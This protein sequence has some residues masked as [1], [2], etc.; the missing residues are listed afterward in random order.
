MKNSRYCFF[1]SPPTR[2]CTAFPE[3]ECLPYSF[4]WWISSLLV[5]CSMCYFMTLTRTAY[6]IC[7]QEEN[8]T[9]SLKKGQQAEIN[10]LWSRHTQLTVSV[11]SGWVNSNSS[12][13]RCWS[14]CVRRVRVPASA[15]SFFLFPLIFF[16][17]LLW[18]LAPPSS[19]SSFHS[20]PA[21]NESCCLWCQGE[22]GGG[23]M[24][25]RQNVNLSARARFCVFF[26]CVCVWL[27]ERACISSHGL[28]KIPFAIHSLARTHR[29]P[30]NPCRGIKQC[31][32]SERA[33]FS[34]PPTPPLSSFV[35]HFPLQGNL[36]F[37]PLTPPLFSLPLRQHYLLLFLLFH[38]AVLLQEWWLSKITKAVS[39]LW[40][41]RRLQA[42]A[43]RILNGPF[44]C[45]VALFSLWF[46]PS[47]W[48][49]LLWYWLLS[50][51]S[52]RLQLTSPAC[53]FVQQAFGC[54][55]FGTPAAV[56]WFSE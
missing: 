3:A 55:F 41:H 38:L 33:L 48:T 47:R 39:S 7:C 24:E 50:K 5:F 51:R 12:R 28:L 42:W 25:L 43:E 21:D 56:V 14:L 53:W 18:S 31:C 15:S 9:N 20:P 2:I 1:F 34:H 10:K 27:C 40:N 16:L 29:A 45:P 35:F 13:T 32:R 26:L 46:A 8:F 52:G 19:M 22:P 17:L 11:K 36:S 6:L 30:M 37:S 44:L 4:L 49:F 23:T 54:A